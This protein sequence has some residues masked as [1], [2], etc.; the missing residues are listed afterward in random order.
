MGCDI[1]S[2]V[3]ILDGEAWK[4]V[5]YPLFPAYCTQDQLFSGVNGHWWSPTVEPFSWRSYGMFAFLANVRNYSH[6]PPL[7]EPRGFPEDMAGVDPE[8]TPL[9]EHSFTW[10]S[11]S[12]LLAFDYDQ[13]FENRRGVGASDLG[14]GNGSVITFREFLGPHFFRDLAIIQSL[15]KDPSTVRVVFGF[16]N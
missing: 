7:S 3:Q 11:V 4:T 10:L 13:S 12:E 15:C 5:E 2:R 1:H 14:Q 16:D 9:G 6:V 8:D